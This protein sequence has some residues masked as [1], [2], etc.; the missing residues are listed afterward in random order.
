MLLP[1]LLL[2][3]AP[4]LLPA[5]TVQ[6]SL[7]QCGPT[8]SRPFE[9]SAPGAGVG[10]RPASGCGDADQVLV[11][12]SDR[13]VVTA[14]LPSIH[15]VAGTSQLA[16]PIPAAVPAQTPQTPTPAP[17]EQPTGDSPAGTGLERW[18]ATIIAVVLAG[19]IVWLTGR[20]RRMRR[21][22]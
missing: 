20:L 12:H 11:A 15:A 5:A 7:V 4:T 17:T 9:L 19:A 21:K 13:S 8:C 6:A 16:E 3:L 22:G 14:A 18:Q 1:A 10:V 2:A